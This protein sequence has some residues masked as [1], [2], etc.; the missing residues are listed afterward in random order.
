MFIFK[1]GILFGSSMNLDE[2]SY[3]RRYFLIMIII[4][5]V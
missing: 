3:L 2:Q 1:L 5:I 4:F